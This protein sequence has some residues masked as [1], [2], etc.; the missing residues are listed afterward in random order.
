MSKQSWLVR[1]FM[2]LSSL[3]AMSVALGVIVLLSTVP[4]A[5]FARGGSHGSHSHSHR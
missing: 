4:S 3:S 2:T 1:A 5:A